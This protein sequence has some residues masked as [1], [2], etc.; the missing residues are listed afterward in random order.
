VLDTIQPFRDEVTKVVRH[1]LA[2]SS[3]RQLDLFPQERNACFYA[4]Q[5]TT[6]PSTL[7]PAFTAAETAL[8]T[9]SHVK[10]AKWTLRNANRHRLGFIHACAAA[11]A[12]FGVALDILFILS[13]ASHFFRVASLVFWWPAL[14]AIY[15]ALHGMCFFLYCQGARALRPWEQFP[16]LPPSPKGSDDGGAAAHGAAFDQADAAETGRCSA[17]SPRVE[18]FSRIDPLR[19]ASLQAFGPKNDVDAEGWTA[20]YA[21]RPLHRRI[22]EPTVP[23]SN[24]RLR[25]LQSRVVFKAIAYGG[26]ISVLL[27]TASIFIPGVRM[28]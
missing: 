25:L 18:T 4:L 19:K 6:H 13:G 8:K 1:Y 10:F 9:Q 23:V 16:D 14:A 28:F 17:E 26:A 24:K 2:E 11:V 27:T 21:G 7:L 3:P 22:F 12:L 20:A 5:Y 15:L